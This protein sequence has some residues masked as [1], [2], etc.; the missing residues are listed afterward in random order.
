MG[1]PNDTAF[2]RT[3]TSSPF[4]KLDDVLPK[5]KISSFTLARLKE[6]A[7][8]AGK[9]L[10]EYLRLVLDTQAHGV[11]TVKRM[12]ADEVDLVVEMRD[13]KGSTSPPGGG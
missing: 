9:T 5:Q 3:G 10:A 12:R 4:G 13:G 11:D 7:G 1:E 8:Q 2:A 6:Q